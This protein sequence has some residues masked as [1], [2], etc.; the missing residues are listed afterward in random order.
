MSEKQEQI[1]KLLNEIERESGESPDS[2]GIDF[3]EFR[4]DFCW[5]TVDI[6]KARRAAGS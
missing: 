2:D 4:K 5:Q 3:G 6:G 1:L